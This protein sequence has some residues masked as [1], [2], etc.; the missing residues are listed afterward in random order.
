MKISIITV[1]LNA[2]QHI[3]QTIRSVLE[4]QYHD[5]QYVIIDGGSDDGTTEIIQ[6]Y[7]DRLTGWIS[8]PDRGISDAMNKGIAMTDGDFLLF[9]HADDYLPDA[10]TLERAAAAI[11]SDAEIHFFDIFRQDG[12][13]QTRATPRGWNWWLNLKTGIFH[14]GALCARSLF[15]RIGNFDTNLRVAMDY[16]FFLRA[17]RAGTHTQYHRLPLSVMRTTGISSRRDRASLRH[18]LN[19]EKS[20][21]QTHCPGPWYRL[22]YSLYWILYPRYRLLR[23]SRPSQADG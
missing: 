17:Y 20:I 8:E 12:E 4:Q 3:E 22:F 13:R 15:E 18:R 16:D 10:H 7:A 19:E 6:R 21:H 5:L 2:R 23:T 11:R 14:Q 9:L 1:S